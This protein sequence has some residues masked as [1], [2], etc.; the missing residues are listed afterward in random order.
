MVNAWKDK[1]SVEHNFAAKVVESGTSE[2][3]K[4][5]LEFGDKY[6]PLD[7]VF[8]PN[9]AIESIMTHLRNFNVLSG[10]TAYQKIQKISYNK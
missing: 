7:L 10:T 8:T 3:V 4:E 9:V 2:I 6:R 5:I 1:S